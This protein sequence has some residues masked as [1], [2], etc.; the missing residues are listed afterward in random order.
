MG[1]DVST[2]LNEARKAG[3]P[4]AVSGGNSY[5]A[6]SADVLFDIPT[7]KGQSKALDV[8]IPFY[9]MVY[10]GQKVLYSTAINTAADME[11]AVVLAVMSGTGLG[12][13]LVQNFDI[14][15]AETGVGK[16]YATVYADHKDRIKA[17][18]EK[19]AAC[20]EAIQGASIVRFEWLDG[21][22]G[23]AVYDNGVALYANPTAATVETVVGSLTGYECKAIREAG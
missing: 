15:Y 6:S 23:K 10:G 11:Q 7:D 17:T 21:G 13:T 1:S 12:Y 20:Y 4:V 16:L 22:V 19:Y 18:T 3:Y 5:A 14:S 9:Q 2:L 8:A